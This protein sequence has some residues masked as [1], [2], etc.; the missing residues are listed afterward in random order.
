MRARVLAWATVGSLLA[1]GCGATGRSGG[2]PGGSAGAGAAGSGGGAA[3]QPTKGRYADELLPAVFPPGASCTYGVRPV[4]PPFLCGSPTCG[5]GVVDSCKTIGGGACE[6]GGGCMLVDVF[7]Q[8][9]GAVPAG[10]SCGELGYSGGK[11]GCT[12]CALDVADCSVC[13]TDPRVVECGELRTEGRV[14]ASGSAALSARGNEV[15]VLFLENND[16]RFARLSNGLEVLSTTDCLDYYGPLALAA[17]EMG[18]LAA[19]T[20]S[21]LLVVHVIDASG[22]VVASRHLGEI[23]E[24]PSMLMVPSANGGALLVTNLGIGLLDAGG[25]ALVAPTPLPTDELE[26]L[27]ATNVAAGFLVAGQFRTTAGRYI[28]TWR[29]DAAGTVTAAPAPLAMSTDG[30]YQVRLAG[31]GNAALAVW[32]DNPGISARLLDENGNVIS[33]VALDPELGFPATAR[34]GEGLAVLQGSLGELGL[35]YLYPDGQLSDDNIPVLTGRRMIGDV[36]MTELSSGELLVTL[37]N[38]KQGLYGHR[39]FA[40]VAPS[41]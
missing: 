4:E 7:E 27:A 41:F 35:R 32:S 26:S 33:V 21:G 39:L 40:R 36:R 17:S 23:G 6:Y 10:K 12:G 3:A 37:V 24:Q 2:A 9:D 31:L 11:L 13:T 38:S 16:L 1:L 29:V 14:R 8:C 18:W 5:N 28:Q 30:P 25:S 19:S 22:Q 34:W 20:F 15:G